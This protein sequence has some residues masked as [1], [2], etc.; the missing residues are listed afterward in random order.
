MSADA[1]DRQAVAAGFTTPLSTKTQ[2]SATH[3]D[4]GPATHNPQKKFNTINHE[5]TAAFWHTF[6]TESG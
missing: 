1:V 3:E 6:M 4:A 2:A 5:S